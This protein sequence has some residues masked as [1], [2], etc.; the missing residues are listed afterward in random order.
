MSRSSHVVVDIDHLV[1]LLRVHIGALDLVQLVYL[2]SEGQ[3]DQGVHQLGSGTGPLWP[4]GTVL[5]DQALGRSGV[6]ELGGID[7]RVADRLPVGVE[8]LLA[9]SIRARGSERVRDHELM[10]QTGLVAQFRI[11]SGPSEP[12][13]DSRWSV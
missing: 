11:Q 13:I 5:L 3:E 1:G 10:P 9:S 12:R 6:S 7:L 4:A 2:G 8:E